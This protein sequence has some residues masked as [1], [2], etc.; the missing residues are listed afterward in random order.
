MLH[1]T[2]S[3]EP[4]PKLRKE[5]GKLYNIL[6]DHPR[7]APELQK[8]RKMTLRAIKWMLITEFFV[9]L[10]VVPVKFCFDELSK[11]QPRIE[12]LLAIALSIGLLYWA[13]TR[14]RFHAGLHRDD[15]HYRMWAN[16]WDLGHLFELLLSADWH[17]AH[18]TGEK[19]SLVSRNI[20]KFEYMINQL[21]FDTI[22]A[23]LR[24]GFTTLFM[25]YIGFPF[26]VLSALTM[27]VYFVVTRFTESKLTKSRV[28]ARAEIKQFEA[29]GSQLTKNWRTIKELGA[30]ERFANEN[31]RMLFEHIRN[32]A[33]RRRHDLKYYIRQENVVTTSRA[34]LYALIGSMAVNGHPEIGSM[35]LASTWMERSY[36]NY[37]RFTDFQ[38][39]L[40]EGLISLV[41]LVG[42]MTLPPT[43]VEDPNPLYPERLKGQVTFEGVSF[44]Y[45]ASVA[46]SIRAVTFSVAA[47]TATA[48]VG[49]T[50]CGKSTLMSLLQRMYDPSEGR[51][52]IDGI[53]MRSLDLNRY[54]QEG[55]AIVSQQI[56][57]FDGSIL[58][59]IRHG[60]PEATDED[61]YEAT[62]QAYADEFIDKLPD[63]YDTQV[64][65][66]GIRLSGGQRQRLALA[67]ALVR[68]PAVLILDEATSAL[69]AQSQKMVQESI[70][71]LIAQKRCTIFLIAH[72][73][74]TIMKT[75]QVIVLDNGEL[76]EFGTH[77]ELAR[78]NGLYKR[79]RD[80]EGE[81]LLD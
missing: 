22:P 23:A 51:V 46:C 3:E 29:F 56:E 47:F 60:N 71:A 24:I 8:I 21:I 28:E 69:D 25:F 19:D 53:D 35:V 42:V 9:A 58:D 33:R 68:K 6:K 32:N 45:P 54:R 39:R 59:N 36:S 38:E 76:A 40:N 11:P 55:L 14:L 16:W 74:A 80:M 31:R 20:N 49:R 66:N 48:I 12:I 81:G 27:V 43:V 61:V 70:D 13:V 41:E 1:T 5:L 30:E 7:A 2:N 64:G 4:R 34:L 67:R 65:D 50:G 62:R 78:Q 63:T 52:L 72:R 10:Q 57:L 44:R 79:L 73:F 75:D 18:G 37:F 15:T 26:G 77:A 17:V